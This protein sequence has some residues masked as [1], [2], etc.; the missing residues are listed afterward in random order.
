MEIVQVHNNYKF[1]GGEE[2]VFEDT[3]NLLIREGISVS[4]LS[5]S[6]YNDKNSNF[7]KI[8]TFFS[9]LYSKSA[10]KEM[11]QIIL[12]KKPDI[13][14][15]HNIYPF[16]ST[17][18][19]NICQKEMIPIVMTCH[20]YRLVCP[21]SICFINNQICERCIGGKEYWCI[22]K[23]CRR[24]IFESTAY[25]WRNVLPRLLNTFQKNISRFICVSEFLKSRFIEF[26]INEK[27][28]AVLP[29]MI[30]TNMIS[31]QNENSANGQ[32]I[33]YVGRLSN[34]KGIDILLKATSKLPDLPVRIAGNGPLMSKIIKYTSINLKILGQLNRSE[35]VTFYKNARFLVVPSLWFETFGLIILEAMSNGIPV[36]ASRIGA[37]PE[38]VEDGIT[39]LL[40]EPGNHIEL[41][42]KMKM[43]W[44]NYDLCKKMGEIGKERVIKKYNE[45]A[46]F[47]NL[48]SIYKH[49]LSFD[50]S[51]KLI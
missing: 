25:A 51:N 14:H 12:N 6:S 31:K 24:N 41:A 15:I 34:E 16:I 10:A 39:G 46:Y 29:N 43:L 23:N 28:I 48:L 49:T 27:K 40:F 8:S 50:K 9:S 35:M 47:N 30:N 2:T 18:I 19:F 33:A 4:I 44:E 38:L 17:S 7:K 26:G 37:I 13:V 45:S 5:R 32:Y 1:K 22:I 11:K 20:N 36:I 21:I 3:V 42:T